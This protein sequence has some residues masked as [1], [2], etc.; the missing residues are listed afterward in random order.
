MVLKNKKF[1]Q[2]EIAQFIQPNA[3]TYIE[4]WITL[5]NQDEFTKRIYFTIRDMHSIVRNLEPSSTTATNFFNGRKADKAPRFDK[6]L[7]AAKYSRDPKARSTNARDK[8][9]TVHNHLADLLK[10]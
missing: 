5:N 8:Y 9:V 3:A 1:K 4:K 10:G 6:I 7:E 2:L